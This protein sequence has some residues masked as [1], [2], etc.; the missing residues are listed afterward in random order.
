MGNLQHLDNSWVQYKQIEPRIFFWWRVYIFEREVAAFW[1][2]I[3][4]KWHISNKEFSFF[5][6]FFF[7]MLQIFWTPKKAAEY[8]K[9]NCP[10]WNLGAERHRSLADGWQVLLAKNVVICWVIFDEYI[11]SRIRIDQNYFEANQEI[12][13]RL[14]VESS[15]IPKKQPPRKRIRVSKKHSGHRKKKLRTAEPPQKTKSYVTALLV[16]QDECL[17]MGWSSPMTQHSS[18]PTNLSLGKVGYKS[19]TRWRSHLIQLKT[20]LA[21]PKKIV[22]A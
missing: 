11:I 10:F 20:N 8:P 4:K 5:C 16:P 19:S 21:V 1:H 15:M 12:Q 9:R 13:E 6:T 22:N 3:N 18:L 7:V 14:L 17:G 2:S